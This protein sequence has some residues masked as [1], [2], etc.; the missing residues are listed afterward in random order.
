MK[1]W[2]RQLSTVLVFCKF[3]FIDRF[4]PIDLQSRNVTTRNR[5]L[6]RRHDRYQPTNSQQSILWR[7]HH[8]TFGH[9]HLP[10]TN[11][12][13]VGKTEP[14]PSSY[15]GRY[16]GNNKLHNAHHA[17]LCTFDASSKSGQGHLYSSNRVGVPQPIMK[18][19]KYKGKHYNYEPV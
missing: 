9:C 11:G 4:F 15:K 5:R 6:S 2:A 1:R 8:P 16:A 12:T 10:P 18:K 19:K 13:F 7:R 14:G 17:G 3:T